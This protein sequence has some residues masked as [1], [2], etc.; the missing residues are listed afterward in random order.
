[1]VPLVRVLE[2]VPMAIPEWAKNTTLY[3]DPRAVWG[4]GI[5]YRGEISLIFS[6]DTQCTR[7]ANS[8][9]KKIHSPPANS[10][11]RSRH[12]KDSRVF[13]CLLFQLTLC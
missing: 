10:P 6:R 8:S 2:A 4:L 5:V 3:F 1:M 12:D 13:P 11:D 7:D 9:Y